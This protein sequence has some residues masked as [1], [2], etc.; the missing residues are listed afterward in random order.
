MK[1]KKVDIDLEPA[2]LAIADQQTIQQLAQ[3]AALAIH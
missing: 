3:N 2:K 1:L